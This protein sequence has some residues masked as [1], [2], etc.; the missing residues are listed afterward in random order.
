MDCG[1]VQGLEQGGHALL[2]R[3]ELVVDP[4]MCD[5]ACDFFRLE[6]WPTDPLHMAGHVPVHLVPSMTSSVP[7]PIHLHNPAP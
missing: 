6:E 5:P 4:E 3:D 1:F 7:V 2:D